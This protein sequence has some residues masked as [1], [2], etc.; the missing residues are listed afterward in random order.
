MANKIEVSWLEFPM[1][2]EQLDNKQLLLL[3]K[4]IERELTNRAQGGSNG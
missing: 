4:L 1:F 3:A 2:L